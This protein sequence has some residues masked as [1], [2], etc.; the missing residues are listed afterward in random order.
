MPEIKLPD[1]KNADNDIIFL[2]KLSKSA[3]MS[4][5][6]IKLCHRVRAKQVQI[7]THDVA[8]MMGLNRG[9]AY[10]LMDELTILEMVKKHKTQNST[11]WLLTPKDGDFIEEEYVKAASKWREKK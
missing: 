3:R 5:L 9:A 6:Y 10:L 7:T 8:S 2:K 11:V 1:I 4:E